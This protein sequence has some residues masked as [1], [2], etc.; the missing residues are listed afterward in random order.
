VY[1]CDSVTAV[2][3]DNISSDRQQ[4]GVSSSGVLGPLALAAG[5]P[6]DNYNVHI[7]VRVFDRLHAF[8]V[9]SVAPVQVIRCRCQLRGVIIIK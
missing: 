1:G 4:L 7:H 2:G 3:M 9:Y 5:S 6:E 8:S